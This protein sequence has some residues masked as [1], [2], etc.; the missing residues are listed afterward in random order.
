MY[1]FMLK[2][3]QTELHCIWQ[4]N[5]LRKDV[6]QYLYLC[7]TKVSTAGNVTLCAQ[8]K[9]SLQVIA[10]GNKGGEGGWIY[11]TNNTGKT[12]KVYYTLECL[13]GDYSQLWI[14][15]P[16]TVFATNI[17][18]YDPVSGTINVENGDSIYYYNAPDSH[19]YAYL[20]YY[21]QP[22]FQF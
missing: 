18:G 21:N 12:I 20:Y 4:K 5:K 19:H 7:I 16:E 10:N 3:M 15:Y 8:W 2:V 9:V 6:E 14:N 11:W 1:Q 22:F 13:S 17:L